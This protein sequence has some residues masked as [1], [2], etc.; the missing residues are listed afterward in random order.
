MEKR[1]C[2]EQYEKCELIMS[3]EKCN[4]CPFLYECRYMIA[5][6]ND[7]VYGD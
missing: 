1:E 7:I 4:G 6:M 5:E 2:K 3:D